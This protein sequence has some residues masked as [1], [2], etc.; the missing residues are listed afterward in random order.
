VGAFPQI[1]S[2]E[3]PK[4]TG[5]VVHMVGCLPAKAQGSEFNSH[6]GQKK[7]LWN[8][9]VKNSQFFSFNLEFG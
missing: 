7:S 3:G 6:H 9:R 4:V 8:Y 5:S 2:P 1:Y